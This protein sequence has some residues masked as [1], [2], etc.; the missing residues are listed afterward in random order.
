MKKED[1]ERN[2][3]I[4]L[5]S[6]EL[7]KYSKRLLNIKEK[8]TV[9]QILNRTINANIFD[10][11]KF[12]PENFVDLLFLDPPYN[13][14]KSF[15]GNNF[16]EKSVEEYS[17][18]IESFLSELIKVLKPN[19]SIYFC[20][21]WHSSTSIYL[22][23]QKYFKI[24]NRITFERGKGRGAKNN[25]KNNSE[26]IWFCTLSNKYTFNIEDVKLKKRVRATYR[27]DK[28]EPKDWQKEEAGSYRLTHPSNVWTDI[29]MP[30]WS[31]PENTEHPTQKPEKLLSKIILAS[32]NKGD[33]VLDP[34]LGSGT[35]SV[36]AK[37]LERNF[38]GIELDKT[39]ASIAEKRLEL[40]SENK[41]IQGYYDGV[42]WER[43]SKI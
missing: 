2:Q 13:M 38:V 43:N 37:K 9:Q 8:V 16:K 19:A 25:W 21:D 40:A 11:I 20:G 35:T 4:K 24:K 5:T 32:S 3:T 1:A 31:M 28:G 36:V 10:V 42:F 39:Y 34:F 41:K 6:S 26:D 18:W 15:N 7:K 23:L 22:V 14:N 29:S 30:F 33:V 27:N 12:L 17:E